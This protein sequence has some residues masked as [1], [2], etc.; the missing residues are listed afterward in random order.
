MFS[1]DGFQ[2]F[3]ILEVLQYRKTGM[4]YIYTVHKID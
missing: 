1:E 3:N 4:C 2:K